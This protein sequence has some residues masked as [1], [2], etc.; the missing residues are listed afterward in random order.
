M[1]RDT[2]VNVLLII[3][4]I[5]LA[6][7]LFGAGVV[8]RNKTATKSTSGNITSG[9][10]GIQQSG[11]P[12]GFQGRVSQRQQIFVVPVSRCQSTRSDRVYF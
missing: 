8:W 7:A 5:V 11:S 2:I 6:I 1:K 3:A 9:E 12:G 10:G 4:G